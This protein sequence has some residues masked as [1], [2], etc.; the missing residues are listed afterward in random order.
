MG[1]SP[2]WIK[3]KTIKLVFGASPLSM[4]WSEKVEKG[5]DDFEKISQT[6][7]KEMGRFDRHRVE[8]FKS[9]VIRYL[10]QLMENQQKVK[11]ILQ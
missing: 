11:I 4:Q 6:I 5:K 1:L 3:S 8:D 7:R 10:E 9:T 2:D